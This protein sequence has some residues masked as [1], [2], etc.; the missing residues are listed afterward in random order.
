[1]LEKLKSLFVG[2]VHTLS[3]CGKCEA[4]YNSDYG[5]CPYC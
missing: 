3:W 2:V 5:G 1:M 4:W